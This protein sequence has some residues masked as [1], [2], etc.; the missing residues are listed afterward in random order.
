MNL[1]TFY[2]RCLIILDF[3]FFLLAC[4][5]YVIGIAGYGA[6]IIQFG[7]DQLFDVP[8]QHQAPF[9]HWA[10]WCND[11]LSVVVVFLYVYLRTRS[12]VTLTLVLTSISSSIILLVF[13]LALLLVFGCWKHHWF[14]SEPPG[15][16]NP[17]KI[18]IKVLNYARKHSYAVQ[19]SAFT[20][21]DDER[22]S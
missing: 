20:Y 9:V 19:R 16:Q 10:K 7:L 8:C 18:V 13:L 22:P 15:H 12:E 2:L 5:A 4:F 17:Y 6:N 3:F 14:Y 21:C 11:L 1:L